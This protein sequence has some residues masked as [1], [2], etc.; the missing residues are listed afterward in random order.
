MGMAI[1][2][3]CARHIK[4]SLCPFCGAGARASEVSA[5]SDTPRRLRWAA[6]AAAASGA[7]LACSAVYGAPGGYYPIP[8]AG[9]DGGLDARPPI[10]GEPACV[11]QRRTF[12]MASTP[13]YRGLCTKDDLERLYDACL[14]PSAATASCQAV[15]EKLDAL[16]TRCVSGGSSAKPPIPGLVPVPVL[17]TT[18]SARVT[19]NLAACYAAAVPGFPEGCADGLME[20]QD[21]VASCADCGNGDPRRQSVC[22]RDVQKVCDAALDATCAATLGNA[23]A[24]TT[25][26]QT[27]FG[28][29]ADDIVLTRETFVTF[30]TYL[31]GP[32]P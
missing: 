20:R 12:L 32:A 11:P 22:G 4:A 24:L 23:A 16:C 3:G 18:A 31:C 10:G 27:C 1:C 5:S 26:R 19:L 21:C 7:V 13:P 2:S 29:S 17:L 9:S 14:G 28:S 25:A 30:G 8:D 15:S 6:A